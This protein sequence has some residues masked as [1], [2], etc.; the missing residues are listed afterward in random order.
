VCI[1][2]TGP[3]QYNSVHWRARRPARA[4]TGRT[5]A[6]VAGN[7]VHLLTGSLLSIVASGMAWAQAPD[8]TA[9]TAH[10]SPHFYIAPKV[11]ANTV[12]SASIAANR[13]IKGS[14]RGSGIVGMRSYSMQP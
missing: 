1:E 10:D 9:R 7:F 6:T 3:C 5:A 4:E 12:C 13:S 14:N 2:K 11:S 8:A